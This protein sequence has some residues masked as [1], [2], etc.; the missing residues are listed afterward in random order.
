ML[1]RD[2]S[3]VKAAFFFD[4]DDRSTSFPTTR[5]LFHDGSTLGGVHRF[6]GNS[7]SPPVIF[8]RPTTRSRGTGLVSAIR[9]L[10]FSVLVRELDSAD[11]F[12]AGHRLDGW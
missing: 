12:S 8:S 4:N 2:S 9:S 7:I 3:L 5:R 1:D 11:L 6:F 10:L